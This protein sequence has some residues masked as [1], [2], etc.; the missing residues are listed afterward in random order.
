MTGL[1]SWLIDTDRDKEGMRIIA[2]LHGGDLNDPSGL[3]EFE[4]IKNNVA[5]EV[6]GSISLD[7]DFANPY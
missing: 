4:E 2:D 6:S 5:F 7:H 1:C 3:Y